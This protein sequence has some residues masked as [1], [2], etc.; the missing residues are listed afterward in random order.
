MKTGQHERIWC[1]EKISSAWTFF[2]A[3]K[4]RHNSLEWW[5]FT[6]T[7]NG[8]YEFLTQ[9]CALPENWNYLK[10]RT[11]LMIRQ[12]WAWD[13]KFLLLFLEKKVKK[14]LKQVEYESARRKR[15]INEKTRRRDEEGSTFFL[16]YIYL[17]LFCRKWQ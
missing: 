7:L 1:L 14:I 8:L 10:F 17:F 11:I 6:W 13:M 16:M 5:L 3:S 15:H 2:K 4:L 9:T 12:K